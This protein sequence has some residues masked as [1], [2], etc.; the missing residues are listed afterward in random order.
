MLL[1]LVMLFSSAA[2]PCA[3]A[4]QVLITEDGVHGLVVKQ[5]K[6]GAPLTY[7]FGSCWSKGNLKTAA[8]WFDEVAKECAN[9]TGGVSSNK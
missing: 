8:E 2:L 9:P 5:V 6:S 3:F 7:Y 4:E 1:T